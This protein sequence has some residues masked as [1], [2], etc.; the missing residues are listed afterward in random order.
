MTAFDPESRDHPRIGGMTRHI[1][2]NSD[3][4]ECTALIARWLH[5]CLENHEKCHNTKASTLPSRVI[6]IGDDSFNRDIRLVSTGG[7]TGVYTALSHCWGKTQIITSTR[8]SRS[9]WEK[10]VP[11]DRLSKTFQDAITVTRRLGVPYIWIDSLCITQDDEDDW[12]IESQKMS[13]I[14][15]GALLVISATL[16]ADGTGGCFSYRAP[17]VELKGID[18]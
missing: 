18:E 4:Q 1:P 15:E 2:V 10:N 9:Q 3:S 6:D 12:Q 11:W 7:S 16:S 13:A 8:S 5:N 17:S 14:Y